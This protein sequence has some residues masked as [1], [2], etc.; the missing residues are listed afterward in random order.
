[1]LYLPLKG[2]LDNLVGLTESLSQVVAQV[3]AS[4]VN[5]AIIATAF[6]LIFSTPVVLF[7]G[8]IINLTIT[9]PLRQLTLLTSRIARGETASRA[10]VSG[11]NEIDQVAASMNNMLDNIVDLMHQTR[12]QR[13]ILQE[14]VEHMVND[15][16]GVGLGDLRRQV[17]ITSDA[18]GFLAKSFNFMI[19]EFANLIVRIKIVAREVEI[20]T[21]TTFRRMTQ[22]VEI[23]DLQMQQFSNST[24]EVEKMAVTTRQMNERAHTLFKIALET[25][26]TAST[27]RGAVQQ[28]V[29]GMERI[30]VNM[31]STSEKVKLLSESSSEIN[32]IV[33]VISNVAFQTNRL[34]LDASVQAAMAGDNGKGFA[35]VA[36]DI[37]RLSEQTKNQA[38]RIASIVRTINENVNNVTTSMHDTEH[39]TDEGKQLAQKTEAALI[40]IFDGVERQANEIESISKMAAQQLRSSSTVVQTMHNV[41]LAT[42]ESSGSTRAASQDMYKLAQLV[43]QLRT[44]VAAFRVPDGHITQFTEIRPEQNGADSRPNSGKL[45]L[46]RIPKT[47]P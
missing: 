20:L 30:H 28:T 27:G 8:Y 37:R 23:S 47:S 5:T 34:A 40:S 9:A 17:P 42:E 33:V 4:Q 14:R 16:Q 2:N 18:L 38:N 21:A 46:R 22:L 45:G 1:M 36:T 41:S 24:T 12:N 39:E 29:E 44:S 6:A 25:Q 35:A 11:H 19:K 31:R 7:I 26:Q 13:D 15:V 32:N 10:I 3:N 43:D